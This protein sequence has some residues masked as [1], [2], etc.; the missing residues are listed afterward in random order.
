M[1][2]KVERIRDLIR[3][4]TEELKPKSPQDFNCRYSR[5]TLFVLNY[6]VDFLKKAND[7]TLTDADI[8]KIEDDL[9]LSPVEI[10]A[11]L[12]WGNAEWN[13]N[14]RTV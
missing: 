7:K 14:K 13:N 4:K 10:I 9:N 1:R 11:K 3:E 2:E 6:S 8:K 12:R 5:I